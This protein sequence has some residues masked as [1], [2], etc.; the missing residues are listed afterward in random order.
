M[1]EDFVGRKNQEGE[2]GVLL[3]MVFDL[4]YIRDYTVRL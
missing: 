2:G 1:F 3:L 4:M